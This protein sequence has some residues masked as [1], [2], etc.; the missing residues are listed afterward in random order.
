MRQKHPIMAV[1]A[2]PE[3]HIQQI[4]ATQF[5]TTT[6]TG[7]RKNGHESVGTTFI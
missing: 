2:N 6:I 4:P 7:Y 3:T 5:G 1:F